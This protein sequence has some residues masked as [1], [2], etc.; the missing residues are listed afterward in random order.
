MYSYKHAIIINEKRNLE[1]EG[2]QARFGERKEKGEMK[3]YY[4]SQ[5]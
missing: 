3:L 5:Q 1:F 2:K 4:I